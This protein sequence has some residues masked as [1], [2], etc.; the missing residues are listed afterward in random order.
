MDAR[1]GLI[2]FMV[3]LLDL[4]E[5][6]QALERRE[7][8]RWTDGSRTRVWSYADLGDRMQRFAAFL[9]RSGMGRGHRIVVWSEN[10]PEWIAVF[11]GALLRG[12]V[13]VPID[14][15]AS[16]ER[17][18]RVGDEAGA[19]LI[20]AGR[21]REEID[22]GA[23][24]PRFA[25]DEV[26]RLPAGSAP[27]ADLEIG[28]D[29]IVEILYTS[30]TTA[31]PKG[32]VHRHRHIVANLNPIAA[33]IE[34]YRH[35]ARPFQPIRFLDLI[36]L[37][38]MF[39]QAMAVFVPP[40][41]GG[42]VVFSSDLDPGSVQRTIRA[43][44]VSVL[45]TVPRVGAGLRRHVERRFASVRQQPSIE[46]SILAR[47]WRHRRIHGAFGWKFWA[48]VVGGARLDEAL[49]A[50][51]TGIGVLVV[52]GYGLTETS[53]VVTVNHP[54]RTRRGTLGRAIRG[55]EVALADDGEILV[56]GP[57]VVEEYIGR[58]G[59]TTRSAKGQLHASSQ[60]RLRPVTHP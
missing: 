58:E 26:D 56:R 16:P 7:A 21:R 14:H 9:E 49:E 54:F 1:R 33:E 42:A 43:E 38:H 13:I 23:L 51:W 59:T 53:P 20:V 35:W 27:V 19:S 28:P 52:Q 50:F 47:L 44:S 48:L 55:L 17:V 39:G 41:L 30:G 24:V 45:V 31:D 34:R 37:S 8:V 46:G 25:I 3:T 29:D 18:R 12:V 2:Q 15:H 36:P 10:R 6:F 11:W 4:V 22:A 57:S 5:N 60:P 40:I 32:V